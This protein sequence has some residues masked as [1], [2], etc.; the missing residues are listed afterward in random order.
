[1]INLF[2]RY[3]LGGI[4]DLGLA[5]ART[6][7]FFPKSRLIRFPIDIRGRKFI[8]FGTGLTTG[9]NC[10]IEA[11]PL[12]GQSTVV[13]FG[14]NVQINDHVHITGIKNVQIGDDV[15]I[16]GKVYISDSQ[17]GNYSAQ[18]EQSD[19]A[20]PPADRILFAKDVAIGNRV[21]LG[22]SVAVLAGVKIGEGA[23]I[24]ANSVVTKDIPE[25]TI[26]AGIPA[27]TVKRFNPATKKWEKIN[28]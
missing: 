15:L 3:G 1:M 10:R 18:T 6:K 5:W 28:D 20:I 24:G 17:H 25:N 21:W 9:R 4:F 14:R 19:P 2:D 11:Y 26:A 8:D 7:L 12:D 27:K 23:I 13:R 22:E 16:A